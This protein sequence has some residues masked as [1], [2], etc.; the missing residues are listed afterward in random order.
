V[1]LDKPELIQVYRGKSRI[2]K[3]RGKRHFPN[4][5]PEWFITEDLADAAAK[6]FFFLECHKNS[7]LCFQQIGA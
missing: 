2:I 5:L 3:S 6:H 4:T 1:N 7:T